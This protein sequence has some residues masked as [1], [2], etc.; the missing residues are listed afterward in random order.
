MQY[1]VQGFDAYN[2]EGKYKNRDEII[3]NIA[4]AKPDI[5]CLEEFNTYH[6]HPKEKVIWIWY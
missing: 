4:S 2:K 5:L 1:N 3:N 6:N